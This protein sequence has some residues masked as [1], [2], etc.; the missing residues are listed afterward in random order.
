VAGVAKGVTG[1]PSQ[2]WGWSGHPQRL[3]NQKKKKIR[4]LGG[5]WTTP[6][7]VVWAG[8]NHPQALGGGPVTPTRPT[9]T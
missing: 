5:G 4:G 1:H 8:R 7:S 3:K 6:R 9:I 2:L